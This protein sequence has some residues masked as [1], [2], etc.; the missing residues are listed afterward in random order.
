M[1]DFKQK[2]MSFFC[3][4]KKHFIAFTQIFGP[5]NFWEE[6]H[7]YISLPKRKKQILK[8]FL[9]KEEKDTWLINSSMQTGGGRSSVTEGDPR[10]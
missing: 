3:F 7:L 6:L 2:Q 1:A 5:A 9:R 4:L 8:S 10:S